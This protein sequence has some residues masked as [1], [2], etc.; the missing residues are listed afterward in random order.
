M[1]NPNLKNKLKGSKVDLFTMLFKHSVTVICLLK[2]L[3]LFRCG[4][5]L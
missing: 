4:L 3:T 2:Y 1:L 5:T